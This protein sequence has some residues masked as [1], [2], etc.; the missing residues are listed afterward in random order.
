MQVA[1]VTKKPVVWSWLIC[2]DS[3]NSGAVAAAH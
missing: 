3:S 1:R 2:A